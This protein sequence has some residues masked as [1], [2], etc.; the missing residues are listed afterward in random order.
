MFAEGPYHRL[1][2]RLPFGAR[3]LG[4]QGLGGVVVGEVT[5]LADG[6]QSLRFRAI[7]RRGEAGVGVGGGLGPL[8]WQQQA[9]P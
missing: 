5:D 4:E 2:Q 6:A 7:L 9:E 1:P 3:Q 8:G